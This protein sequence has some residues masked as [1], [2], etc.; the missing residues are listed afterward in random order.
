MVSHPD[1]D[2]ALLLPRLMTRLAAIGLP[3]SDT[4]P[5]IAGV[6]PE[7]HADV[8]HLMPTEFKQAAVLVP[9]VQ[10]PEGATI[11]LTE[12]AGHLHRHAG[13]I[14]FPG[15]RIEPDDA[16]PLQAAL[17]ETEEEIGLSRAYVQVLG[18]LAPHWVFTG[19]SITPVIGLVTPGFELR[20]HADEVADV[21][22]VPLAHVF[23]SVNHQSRLRQL[24]TLSIEVYDIP[25]GERRIWG[26]TAGILMSLYRLLS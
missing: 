20:L 10:R 7:R 14:S 3:S 15:G 25:F 22:E 11:L 24:G 16:G 9:I 21:F 12:R 18:Y 4:P 13:Q 5:H 17:R 23:D 1:S 6:P 19:Y 8:L 26:A 2:P